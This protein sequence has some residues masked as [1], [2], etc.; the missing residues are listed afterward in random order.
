M[1]IVEGC[2]VQFS[3]H[4]YSEW[5]HFGASMKQLSDNFAHNIEVCADTID[6]IL[7]GAMDPYCDFKIGI[8]ENPPRRK[9]LYDN[10]GEPVTEM[11]L[12]YF[13]P[14]SKPRIAESTGQMERALISK[15]RGREGCQNTAPGGERPSEGCPHWVYLKVDDCHYDQPSKLQ[16]QK[17]TMNM[18]VRPWVALGPWGI[19]DRRMIG[20]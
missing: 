2:L 14:T 3:A 19:L 20:C 5:L 16:R 13:A 4:K 8:T 9:K 18:L 1:D 11:H 12:I 7:S 6:A 10:S 15:F 17:E